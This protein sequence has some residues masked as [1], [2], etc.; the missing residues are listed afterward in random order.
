MVCD[1]VEIAY[2]IALKITWPIFVDFCVSV[3]SNPNQ[4]S[5]ARIISS[6]LILR[7]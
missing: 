1:V 7:F 5:S 2:H 6:I 4:K 3:S